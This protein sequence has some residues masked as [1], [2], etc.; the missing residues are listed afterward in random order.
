MLLLPQMITIKNILRKQNIFYSLLFIIFIS[1]ISIYTFQ[2]NLATE[3]S[4]EQ[5][6]VSYS[7]NISLEQYLEKNPMSIRNKIALIELNI[8]PDLNSLRCLGRTID[9]TSVSF[10]VDKTVATSHKLLKIVNFLT[11]TII[12]LLFLLFSKNSRFQFIIILLTAY[13]TFSNIFFGSIVFNYYFLIY[14]LTVI[15]YSFLNFDN[16][17]EHKIIDIYIFINVTLL[18]FY[19]DFYTLLLPFFIIFYFFFLKGNLSDRHLKIVSLGGIF[20]YFLRQ[21]SG[22][23]EELTYVWQN[24]SSSMFRGTPRFA[25]MYYTFAVLDCN[26]T[27]C[28]FKN[29]YGPLWEYLAIDLNITMASYI[30]STLLILITQFFFYNFV[31]KSGD[32]GLLIYFVYIAPPTSFLLERMNFDIFVII[33]GY[34]ALQK[35][36]EG[37]KTISLIVLTILTL[38]KIF[39]VVLIVGIAIS[40]YLNKNKSSF[41]KIL[42]LIIGNIVIYLFYFIFNLQ[43]G[44]IARP[45]GIS[46][47]FG[48]PTDVS[49]YLQ[50]F[51]NL[52]YFLYIT[53]VL[54]CIIIYL[55]YLKIKGPV[56]IFSSEDSLLEFSF[57]LCFVFISMYYNF[58][59]RISVFSIGLILLIKNYSLWK[60]EM[61]S[62][63]FLSTCVSN[64]YTINLMSTD[65]INFY[66]SSGVLLINQITFNLV[67]IFLICEIFYFLRRK[68]LFYFFKSLSKISK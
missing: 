15:W 31:K 40:E 67:F 22:P 51:G 5:H 18:I 19:Y 21:L 17:R 64:F 57:S 36:S 44:E 32:K 61:I 54:I 68:E 43:S 6:L 2:K 29:N 16:H 11:V 9:Y 52:G 38:V 10:N 58:D 42:L 34:F 14:P 23:L 48:L 20:Y 8:F 60:F 3:I 46:W 47:T 27:G 56:K 26:K 39:P 62:L 53:T 66:F 1:F 45:T 7:E 12:Y 49:N 37:K 59:F 24:L 25:D 4:C 30:T 41:L 13:L 28:G 55:K 50:L 63:L 65:P 35:Y 33:L